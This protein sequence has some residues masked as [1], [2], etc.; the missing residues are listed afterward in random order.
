MGLPERSRAGW[1]EHHRWKGAI[2]IGRPIFGGDETNADE[3][4]TMKCVIEKKK[5]KENDNDANEEYEYIWE[6]GNN[7]GI[8]LFTFDV[9][10]VDGG[11]RYPDATVT[12]VFGAPGGDDGSF[13][14]R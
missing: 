14:Y 7:R 4:V 5:K 13:H 6:E 9:A 2:E 10:C 1:S 11:L 12:G 3:P 8:E